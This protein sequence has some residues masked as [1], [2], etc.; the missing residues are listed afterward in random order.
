MMR[1][2]RRLSVLLTLGL[3]VAC[4]SA[5]T[6]FY[7][8][9]APVA[10]TASAHAALPYQFE[11]LSVGIPEQ[12]DQPQLVIRQSDA[13]VAVL[14]GEQWSG[15][16]GDQI[17]TAL[18]ADLAQR[19]GTDDVHGL[20]HSKGQTVYRIKL[21]VRRF[22][23]MPGA[24]ALIA[25]A[26]SVR[27]KDSNHALSCIASINQPVTDAGYG[28]VVEGY[29]RALGVLADKVAISVQRLAQGGHAVC[30]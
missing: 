12:V 16:L 24:Y 4:S 13:R 21:D 3:L 7:T 26:W 2:I 5:P 22:E 6:R 10:A 14:E 17:H 18:S 11:L 9:V 30:P 23:A 8:L 20:P 25:G 27:G 19:L 29:Q 15:P 1:S 28:A